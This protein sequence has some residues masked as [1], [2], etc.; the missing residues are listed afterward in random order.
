[1][2]LLGLI[3]KQ[4][5]QQAKITICGPD[6]VLLRTVFT[7]I[8]TSIRNSLSGVLKEISLHTKE[9]MYNTLGYLLKI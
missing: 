3:A 2:L 1:M 9:M 7:A 6:N 4:W 8:I 5:S